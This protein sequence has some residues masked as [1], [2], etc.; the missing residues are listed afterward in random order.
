MNF[1][2]QST[3]YSLPAVVLGLSCHEYMHA[4]AA[5]SLG[6]PTARNQ[7]RLSLNP[8]RHLDP[9][10]LLFIVVAGFGW[11]RPVMFDR[12]YLKKPRRD[13]AL[14]ALA[15]PLA[16]L[17][18]GVAF[19]LLLKLTLVL[20]PDGSSAATGVVL[21][22]GLNLLLYGVFINFGLFVFNLIP[23]PPLDGSHVLLS[24]LNIEPSLEAKLYRYGMPA[25]FA[26]LF[27]ENILKIDILPIGKVVRFMVN[28]LF[29]ALGA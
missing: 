1:D 11:A 26:I 28:V 20:S 7:G 16:N 25:L 3:L 2:L 4:R 9:V 17:L 27:L 29:R 18:L 8:M 12:R 10:G 19:A 6:D 13:E 5:Y 21:G 24:W 23:L 14:I 15:G 22:A